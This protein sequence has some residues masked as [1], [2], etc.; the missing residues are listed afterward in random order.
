MEEKG[1]EYNR[2]ER[3]YVLYPLLIIKM[4][5]DSRFLF[6]AILEICNES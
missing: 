4:I 2:Q 5:I 3:C 6:F 1:I